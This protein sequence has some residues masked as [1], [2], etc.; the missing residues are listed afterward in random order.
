MQPV[1]TTL[2][3]LSRTVIA[4]Q[5]KLHPPSH[6][7]LGSEASTSIEVATPPSAYRRPGRQLPSLSRAPPSPFAEL[8]VH[9]ANPSHASAGLGA[10]PLPPPPSRSGH[11]GIGPRY[12]LQPPS[13]FGLGTTTEVDL[14]VIEPVAGVG[15][16]SLSIHASDAEDG[17]LIS[18][19][20]GG[21][22]TSQ[23]V[24]SQ[25]AAFSQDIALPVVEKALA[26]PPD[27]AECFNSSF[28]GDLSGLAKVQ[29]LLKS[30]Q[31]PSNVDMKV[32]PTNKEIFTIR[33]G[34]M[35][36][37]RKADCSLQN[38]QTTLVK[39]SY[40]MMKVADDLPKAEKGDQSVD[41]GG[42]N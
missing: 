21:E 23:F 28:Q 25:F 16:D 37:L 31:R 29:A 11:G 39:S 41:V 38:V 32:K 4:L 22:S 15:D 33:H 26:L 12:S 3:A 17:H 9:T 2:E 6:Y 19:A 36:S 5:H 24:A 20:E 42:H 7:G 14:E 1:N 34:A 10:A 13:F 35:P 27:M 18:E 40:S 30:I 8:G